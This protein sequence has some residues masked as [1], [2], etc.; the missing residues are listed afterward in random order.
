[1]I[2][3]STTKHCSYKYAINLLYQHTIWQFKL[4]KLK[5]IFLPFIYMKVAT[6]LILFRL[7]INCG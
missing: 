2:T 5:F 7:F 1:V 6:L 4:S 3:K